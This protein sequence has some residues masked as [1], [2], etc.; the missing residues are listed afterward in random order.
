MNPRRKQRLFIASL[1][2][3]GLAA[4]A[5]LILTALDE[6]IDFFYSPTEILHGKKETGLKPKIGQRLRIGGMVKEGS[7]VRSEKDLNVT[8]A[9]Q[10]NGDVVYVTFDGILPDLFREGQGIVAQG[11]LRSPNK[12]E[13]FEVLAKHDEEYMPPEIAEAMKGIKHEKPQ[14]TAEQLET[15]EQKKSY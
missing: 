5:A 9:L 13:A 10:T 11:H 3:L 15:L 1:L 12:V 6:N 14:Y 4:G 2:F 7:V 8:F